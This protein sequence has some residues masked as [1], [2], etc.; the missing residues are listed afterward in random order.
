MSRWLVFGLS[1]MIGQA[2]SPHLPSTGR[3]ILAPTRR[4]GG[5][6]IQGVRWIGD[7]LPGFV[8]DTPAF[9]VVLSL[10]PLDLFADWLAR[11]G[12]GA[13]RLVAISSCSLRFKASSPEPAERELAARLQR[14]EDTILAVARKRGIAATILRPTLIYGNGMDRSLTPMLDF[15]RRWRVLPLPSQAGGRRQPVHVDDVAHAVFACL[16]RPVSAGKVYELPG[17]EVLD[18]KAMMRRLARERLP[19]AAVVSLPNALFRPLLAIGLRM[20]GWNLSAG[21][22]VQRLAQDQVADAS[23]ARRDLGF[24]PRA[25]VP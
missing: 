14:S 17:G 9:D 11:S 2:V 20:R 22:I 7:A 4:A 23:A 10:G 5:P 16:D 24:S 15:A 6:A 8:P 3:E 21:G 19:G 18:F 25:F 1:G 12:A 13:E